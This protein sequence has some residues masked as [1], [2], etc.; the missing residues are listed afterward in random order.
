M[1]RNFFQHG[2]HG[3]VA[4]APETRRID[5]TARLGGQ[6]GQLLPCP[7]EHG[8]RV[9]AEQLAG[10]RAGPARLLSSL[11]D[12]LF[13]LLELR[14]LVRFRGRGRV[15]QGLPRVH[16]EI[17]TG[18]SR[19][20]VP[21][22]YPAPRHKPLC[23]RFAR[24]RTAALTPRPCV[25]TTR[26]W[27]PPVRVS[28]LI[29]VFVR[30]VVFVVPSPSKRPPFQRLLGPHIAGALPAG[31]PNHRAWPARVPHV[32]VAGPRKK[33]LQCSDEPG[34]LRKHLVVPQGE[35]H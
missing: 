6:F 10:R 20:P 4:V 18:R 8:K 12:Q 1:A 9:A 27:G 22:V 13:L 23:E 11:G 25:W 2:P 35:V 26:R 31:A 5:H 14:G 30:L 17:P 32:G 21:P 7:L 34:H 19:P 29:L 33:I 24:P 15:P 3:V 28:S 16:Q